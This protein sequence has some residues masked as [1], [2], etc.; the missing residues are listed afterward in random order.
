MIVVDR[1]DVI[2]F[3]TLFCPAAVKGC[4]YSN[5]FTRIFRSRQ[6]PTIH[7][8]TSRSHRYVL[9]FSELEGKWKKS[10]K[11]SAKISLNLRYFYY[12]ISEKIKIFK[13]LPISVFGSSC[14]SLF[15]L[16][17]SIF[18]AFSIYCTVLHDIR[19]GGV[20]RTRKE[21]NEKENETKS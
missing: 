18:F 13:F 4:A 17:H 9:K 7:N 2:L 11:L 8:G 3:L 1:Y 16:S 5:T 20:V 10:V 15:S 12:C 6:V 21:K 19:G 14:N